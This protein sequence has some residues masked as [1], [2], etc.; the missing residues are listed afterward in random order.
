MLLE[1]A[2]LPALPEDGEAET[3][4]ES[5]IDRTRASPLRQE[6]HR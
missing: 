2:M 5:A 3:V 6:E 1:T 4:L